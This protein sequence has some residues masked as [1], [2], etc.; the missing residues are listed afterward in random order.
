MNLPVKVFFYEKCIEKLREKYL[1]RSYSFFISLGILYFNNSFENDKLE[2]IEKIRSL[3]FKKQ[4]VDINCFSSIFFEKS[5]KLS[6][7]EVMKLMKLYKEKYK[8]QEIRKI[9]VVNFFI[10]L[11]IAFLIEKELRRL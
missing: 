11:G 7:Q 5:I 9:Q 10:N 6:S 1:I 3:I 8:M 2:L 4:T